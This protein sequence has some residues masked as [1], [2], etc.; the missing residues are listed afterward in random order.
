M[1]VPFVIDVESLTPDQAWTPAMLRTCHTQLLECWNRAGLLVHDGKAYED[2]ALKRAVD[3]LPLKLRSMWLTMLERSPPMPCENNW[4]G[5]VLPGHVQDLCSVAALALVEDTC[6]E[7]EFGFTEEQDEAAFTPTETRRLVVCRLLAAPH[8]SLI[9][10]AVAISQRNIEAGERYQDIWNTRFRSLASAPISSLKKIAIV[11]R[12]VIER[13]FRCPHDQLSGLARFLRLLDE[14]AG[15]VRYVT[16][17]S[18]WT[19]N[20]ADRKIKDV[21][22]EI[23][24]IARKLP[25]KNVKRLTIRM[26]PNSEFGRNA[27]DRYIRFGRYVWELGHGLDIFE[28]PAARHLCQASFKSDAESHSKV[29]QELTRKSLRNSFEIMN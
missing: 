20:L 21:E 8:A 26:V 7:V 3:A 6:A 5:S 19:S 16:V 22:T 9:Q 27:R 25:R 18:A 1:L 24:A 12:Y 11:D 28:G 13:H 15:G 4:N 29:E 2:S 14:D 10:D 23:G 17:Y